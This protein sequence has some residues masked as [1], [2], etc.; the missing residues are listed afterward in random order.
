MTNE[1]TTYRISDTTKLFWN[2]NTLSGE[3]KTGPYGKEKSRE[4]TIHHIGQQVDFDPSRD[5]SG[6]KELATQI[7]RDYYNSDLSVSQNEMAYFTKLQEEETSKEDD[8]SFS[9]FVKAV[10]KSS[11]FV[12]AV[13][14]KFHPK[15]IKTTV[16]KEKIEVENHS[17]GK[18][19]VFRFDT[20]SV[21]TL[22]EMTTTGN[23][24]ATEHQL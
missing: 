22:F 24:I 20:P 21:Y 15:E 18:R 7:M 8:D 2:H 17:T 11:R 5:M 23:E 19:Y 12:E 13:I 9:N 14:N 6:L 1:A 4:I 10:N 16:E 3:L